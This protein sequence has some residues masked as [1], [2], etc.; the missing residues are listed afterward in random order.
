MNPAEEPT[1]HDE[2]ALL[3]AL[4]RQPGDARVVPAGE[5]EL[6]ARL[7]KLPGRLPD[8]SELGQRVRY[9][10]DY[11]LLE[12]LGRGG[13]GVVYRA[14]QLSLQR[15]VAVK[16]LLAGQFA[17]GEL[18]ERFRREAEAVA[19]L[20][21][22]HIIP[23]YEIGE[24]LEQHYFSMKLVPGRNLTESRSDWTCAGNF[25]PAERCR[26]ERAA[27]GL[28][29]K[30]ARA[31]HHAHQHGVLHRDVKPSNVLLDAQ[32]EP[33]VTDFGL[34]KEL[35]GQGGLTVTGAILGTPAY[36]S[37]EQAAGQRDL[38]TAVDVYGLGAIL[39]ELLTNQPPYK[40]ES[41]AQTL[42]LVLESEPKLPRSINPALDRDLETICLKCMRKDPQE[43]YVSAA[44]LADELGR[45]LRGEPIVARPVSS[46]ERLLKWARR[47]P[48]AAALA[49]VSALA[50]AGLFVGLSVSNAL[51]SHARQETEQALDQTKTSLDREEHASYLKTIALAYRDV[52]DKDF[53]HAADLLKSCDPKKC[54]W[55][56]HYLMRR[57][58]AVFRRLQAEHPVLFDL[59]Y[60]PDGK[61]LASLT[62]DLQ[63]HRVALEIWNADSG[64]KVQ[65]IVDSSAT[66]A[67]VHSW[68][69]VPSLT[70]NHDGSQIAFTAYIEANDST[71]QARKVSGVVR[72]YDTKTWQSM[73]SQPETLADRYF[74]GVMFTKAG[75]CLAVSKPAEQI[76]GRDS[77]VEMYIHDLDRDEVVTKFTT[78][79]RA[80]KP[81][82]SPDEQHFVTAVVTPEVLELATGKLI[83]YVHIG[84][85]AESTVW[86]ADGKSLLLAD[87]NGR[88]T[89]SDWPPS[90][91]NG[92]Q[93]F[94]V[95]PHL[96]Y[97]GDCAFVG[98]GEQFVSVGNDGVA[99]LSRSTD[100][101]AIDSLVFGGDLIAVDARPG[102]S[103]IAMAT[104]GGEIGLWNLASQTQVSGPLAPYV[105]Y[106][107]MHVS[108]DGRWAVMSVEGD[109]AAV[110]DLQRRA[111]VRKIQ[112]AEQIDGA[113]FSP[114][115]LALSNDGRLLA[116]GIGDSDKTD[117]PGGK[118]KVWDVQTGT[119]LHE[120]ADLKTGPQSLAWTDDASML[121]G[122]DRN[123]LLTGWNWPGREQVWQRK[124][125][126][127]Y[128][129]LV[130]RPRSQQV[131]LISFD[132]EG[133]S[134]IELV[135]GVTG[136]VEQPV[137][138]PPHFAGSPAFSADGKSLA[139]S[140]KVQGRDTKMSIA[141]IDVDSGRET[142]RLVGGFDSVGDIAF[143]PSGKRLFATYWDGNMLIWDLETQTEVLGIRGE[144]LDLSTFEMSSQG[145]LIGG[146]FQGGRLHI[147]DGTPWNKK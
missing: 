106:E 126:R 114:L 79:Q 3:R 69:W 63:Q 84:R 142:A 27:A 31:V 75:K 50:L 62:E 64:E 34:A 89:L 90:Y 68:R 6:I 7:Q 95:K 82:L 100:G 136:K 72:R 135:D 110:W 38:T 60:S 52:L 94:Q 15:D 121:V 127:P 122:V 43:R 26:R 92:K 91:G 18:R 40:G 30:V 81:R 28:L 67:G 88:I 54:D 42:R 4:K 87:L 144:G 25:T 23:V 10:G 1:T 145:L 57:S 101:K 105:M 65:T 49:I 103:E 102:G 125:S 119:L 133:G 86:S 70:F 14:R 74:T 58:N 138:A 113:P 59:A 140:G 21:H 12:P 5:E 11:E 8:R 134:Q 39:Y 33:H 77:K 132:G 128:N 56:W 104:S 96:R 71:P 32:N 55:E 51:I 115:S 78:S 93:R 29:E 48:A 116:S 139:L 17:S 98:S 85:A 118:M 99:R 117:R 120:I 73:A 131:L 76:T 46:R 108:R 22:P 109:Y 45:Y 9:V 141:L 37:P 97:A 13:M 137:A 66:A 2:A 130:S 146:E 111:E 16:M 112:I 143:S 24:H 80:S 124:L 47:R 19:H 129:M 83:W 147:L 20:D 44:E 61:L 53:R 35:N 107:H 41:S 123:Q 36:M